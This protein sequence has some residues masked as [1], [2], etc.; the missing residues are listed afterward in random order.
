M[1]KYDLLRLS[2]CR[3]EE[4]L[5]I[6]SED[7]HEKTSEL[8]Q[9]LRNFSIYFASLRTQ[10]FDNLSQKVDQASEDIIGSFQV[11]KLMIAALKEAFDDIDDA[12]HFASPED[13]DEVGPQ[14]QSTCDMISRYATDYSRSAV[15]ILNNLSQIEET[16]EDSSTLQ[17][18]PI[19]RQHFD[20]INRFWSSTVLDIYFSLKSDIANF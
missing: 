16:V 13:V 3:H 7:H 9:N 15:A 6:F 18:V 5:A 10:F 4:N 8:G 14:L 19:I 11:T 20:L 1:D 12:C 17:F 2:L